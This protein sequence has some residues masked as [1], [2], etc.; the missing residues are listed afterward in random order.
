ML[1]RF[2]NDQAG[3]YAAPFKR[4]N[5]PWD[6]VFVVGTAA[7]IATDKNTIGPVSNEHIDLNRN[8]SNAGI[9]SMGAAAETI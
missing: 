8:I 2:A 5:L 9:Y 7:L 1:V 4:P 6:A 3:L